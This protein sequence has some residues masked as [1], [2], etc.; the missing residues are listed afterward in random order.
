MLEA[1]E[2]LGPSVV[3]RDKKT[4]AFPSVASFTLIGGAVWLALFVPLQIQFV[5]QLP[6]RIDDDVVAFCSYSVVVIVA[7]L[8]VPVF[9]A[10]IVTRNRDRITATTESA[11]P[12]KP[13]ER[14]I[15]PL[16]TAPVERDAVVPFLPALP[17]PLRIY[18][19]TLITAAAVAS[20]AA[21]HMSIRDVA[22]VTA[23]AAVIVA[24]FALLTP[25]RAQTLLVFVS[26]ALV[27]SNF[28]AIIADARPFA[29]VVL[30]HAATTRA[31]I[32]TPDAVVAALCIVAIHSVLLRGGYVIAA[33]G[34]TALALTPYHIDDD[35]DDDGDDFAVE[36][37]H[38]VSYLKT[39]TLY[40]AFVGAAVY[41]PPTM[42]ALSATLAALVILRCLYIYRRS[43]ID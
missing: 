3:R 7:L 41:A 1:V 37:A 16:L 19:Q 6:P 12:V 36:A 27:V 13:R 28:V 24:A 31:L 17:T 40:A 18:M 22:L 10:Q 20:T 26:G 29:A 35:M 14:L 32:Y 25:N 43:S 2:R 5:A 42:P 23:A 38:L 21:A 30:S 15:R 9:I 4:Y 8:T 33:V 11:A 39:L 34:A